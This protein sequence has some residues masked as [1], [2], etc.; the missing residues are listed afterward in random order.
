MPP[1]LASLPPV[2]LYGIPDGVD[3]VRATLAAMARIVREWRHRPELT[4][5]TRR[6]VANLPE[7]DTHAEMASVFQFVRDCVRYVRDTNGVERIQTPE[8]TLRYLQG[9]CDDQ[10]IL[11]AGMLESIGI[12]AR[13]VA[14][15][16]S[17]DFFEHVYVEAAP[18]FSEWIALD[19]TER[20]EAGWA[21]PDPV[22]RINQG[23]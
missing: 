6:L 9:D 1:L 17:P 15:G 7:K 22:T 16:F 5:Y 13:F 11:L 2:A 8:Y 3:G 14:V 10:A 20:V 12:P 19:P 18:E 4:E 23:I 21:P